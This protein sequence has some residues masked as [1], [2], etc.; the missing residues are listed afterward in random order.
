MLGLMGTTEV[1]EVILNS[2]HFA[3]AGSVDLTG[4]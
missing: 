1:E 2:V 3:S 4:R